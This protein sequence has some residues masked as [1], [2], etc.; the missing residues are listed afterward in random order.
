MATEQWRPA[1]AA[2]LP[3]GSEGSDHRALIAQLERVTP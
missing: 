3:A 2:V 1:G